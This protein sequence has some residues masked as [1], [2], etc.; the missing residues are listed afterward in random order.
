MKITSFQR[1]I[2]FECLLKKSFEKHR[3]IKAVHGMNF[4]Q[5]VNEVTRPVSGT[6]L[7]HIY[8]NHPQRILH[9]STLNC[10]LSDHIPIFAVR[11]YNNER[12]SCSMQKNQNIRY[13]DMKQFDE[14]RFK[15]ALSQ[16][17]W[18]TVF[19]FDEIDDML[20]SWESLFNSV[21]DENCPWM[22]SSV[23]KQLHLRDNCQKP[24]R[25]FNNADDWSNYWSGKKKSS[26]D[27]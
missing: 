5:L 19:V 26:C 7:D 14:N 1:A 6:C 17:P 2:R 9:I 18:D 3:L 10:G 27:D 21:L 13:R 16:A 23:L 22:T 15:E 4:T 12:A 20:D 11:K 8:S 25:C 24:A